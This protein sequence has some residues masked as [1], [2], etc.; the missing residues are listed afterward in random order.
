MKRMRAQLVI[1]LG[2][3]KRGTQRRA[4][5][6]EAARRAGKKPGTWAREVLLAAAS[7]APS[8]IRLKIVGG[9]VEVVGS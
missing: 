5:I 1:A 4:T 3:G 6:E 7:D 8:E 9:V 2:E